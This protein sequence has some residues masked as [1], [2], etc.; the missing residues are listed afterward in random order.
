M[1]HRA[2]FWELVE[3][4]TKAYIPS[5]TIRSK[6]TSVFFHF[7]LDVNERFLFHWTIEDDLFPPCF[8][9]LLFASTIVFITHI[10][11]FF[12]FRAPRKSCFQTLE[13]TPGRNPKKNSH[14]K[15]K[16]PNDGKQSK[17]DEFQNLEKVKNSRHKWKV[18]LSSRE[19][20][21]HQTLPPSCVSRPAF[22][23]SA[24]NHSWRFFKQGSRF[25]HTLAL[26]RT[27]NNFFFSRTVFASQIQLARHFGKDGAIPRCAPH[28]QCRL[29]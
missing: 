13:K 6:G 4:L 11:V 5:I 8:P 25:C 18:S 14:W 1:A 24:A 2:L 12:F 27:T 10:E 22:A 7:G 3:V 15:N 29:H 20:K 21:T 28:F 9:L 16:L 23:I 26:V 19:R 17:P